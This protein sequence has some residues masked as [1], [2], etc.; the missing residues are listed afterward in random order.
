M[1]GVLTST[2]SDPA[3]SPLDSAERLSMLLERSWESMG[4]KC[5]ATR[6]PRPPSI[7]LVS[8]SVDEREL[9]ARSLRGK[10]YRVVNAATTVMAYQIATTRPTDMVVTD[11]HSAG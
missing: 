5:M 1:H 10:G 9:Y 2:G 8:N 7:L 6:A 11:G 3:E 4:R